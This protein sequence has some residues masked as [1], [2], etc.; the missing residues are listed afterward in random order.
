[1]KPGERIAG[2]YLLE[3]PLGSGG[4]GLVFRARD[5]SLGREVAIKLIRP[6]LATVPAVVGRFRRE[7]RVLA[8]LR[9]P[10]AAQ[11]HDFGADGERGFIVMELIDGVSLAEILRVERRLPAERAADLAG[12]T[13]DVLAAA[14]PLGIVHR[15]L[16][17]SNLL[18]ERRGEVEHVRVVDFGTALL[19][20]DEGPRITDA[21]MVYGTPTYM[22]PEQ[23]LG[24]P[25]DARSDLYSLSCTLYEMLT[26]QPPFDDRASTSVMMAHVH[27]APIPPHKLVPAAGIPPQL[28]ALVLRGLAKLPAQRFPDAAT[29]RAALARALDPDQP[30]PPP[31]RGAA[32]R[33]PRA[34]EAGELAE[35][36][37]TVEAGAEIAILEGTRGAGVAT[38]LG[39]LGLAACPIAAGDE[40]SRFRLVV[41]APGDGGED[42]LDAAAAFVRAGQAPVLLCGPEDDLALM[43]RAIEAG[44]HDYLPLPLDP[45]DLARKVSRALRHR[46]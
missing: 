36:R 1:M 19:L 25:V 3:A 29:M 13:L 14:H 21:G 33:P 26:G 7:A 16:K 40:V 27:R 23:C 20:G 34:L 6:S 2:R 42:R 8:R 30:A 5:E 22:A 15:D 43:A 45:A 41:I 46:G 44:V 9:H 35:A 31:R 12:Q 28:E 11:V 37:A 24:K 39:A 10:N 18:I 17:P 32:Q 38:A 4:S